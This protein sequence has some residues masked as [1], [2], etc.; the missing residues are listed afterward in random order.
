MLGG[1]G[2]GRPW[3]D[4][5]APDRTGQRERQRRHPAG[6]DVEPVRDVRGQA[7]GAEQ[8]DRVLGTEGRYV[9]AVQVRQHVV[10]TGSGADGRHQGDAVGEASPGVADDQRRVPVQ[11]LGVV[12]EQKDP[13]IGGHGL[14]QRQE[15]AADRTTQLVV[16]RGSDQ[17]GRELLADQVRQ[18]GQRLVGD[19]VEQVL[20]RGVRHGLLDGGTGGPQHA[21]RE[22]R[23]DGIEEG[24]LADTGRSM[25]GK[26]TAPPQEVGHLREQGATTHD[27]RHGPHSVVTRSL[28]G[29]P[30]CPDAKRSCL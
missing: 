15:G 17:P 29:Y 3:T 6:L 10:P 4:G 27:P 24:A 25:Q 11:P 1:S 7:V 20:E 28:R 30:L 16:A 2:L 5:R 13:G 22:L 19:V 18:A 14:E 26:R 21:G 12:Q 9:D 8:L 23:L